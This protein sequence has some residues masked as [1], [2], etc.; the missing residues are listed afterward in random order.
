ME[1]ERR[2]KLCG[3]EGKFFR[4]VL[5]LKKSDPTMVWNKKQREKNIFQRHI[6][7]P[8]PLTKCM[9]TWNREL[10]YLEFTILHLNYASLVLHSLRELLPVWITNRK[11][12]VWLFSQSSQGW[13]ASYSMLVAWENEVNSYIKMEAWVH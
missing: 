11:W 13:Y 7:S 10:S 9:R 6:W 1:V 4:I 12:F 5:R 8:H 3:K 2:I